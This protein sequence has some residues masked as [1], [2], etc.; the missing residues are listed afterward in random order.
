MNDAAHILLGAGLVAIG[1][2]VA[3]LADRVR[4]LQNT[5]GRA[6]AA[7]DRDELSRTTTP[8]A[9]PPVGVPTTTAHDAMKHDVVSALVGAGYSKRIA[10]DA[11]GACAPNQCSTIESWT[12]GA[13]RHCARGE[14]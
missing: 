6:T 1:V 12:R 10:T 11:A 9:T 13:L 14:A 3:A 8:L 4:G 2:L 5:R 7:R